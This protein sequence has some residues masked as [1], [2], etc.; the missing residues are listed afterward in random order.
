[1]RPPRRSSTS[2]SLAAPVRRTPTKSNALWL[3]SERLHIARREAEDRAARL[4]YHEGQA[5]RLR[6]ALG[7]LVARHE[8]EVERLMGEGAA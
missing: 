3:A 7:D 6:H 2:S 1:M 8:A 5:A 4:A